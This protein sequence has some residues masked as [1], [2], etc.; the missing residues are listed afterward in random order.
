[1]ERGKRQGHFEAETIMEGCKEEVA[2][3]GSRSQMDYKDMEG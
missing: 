1:M 3:I 2:W